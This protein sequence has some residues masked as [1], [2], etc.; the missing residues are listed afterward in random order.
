M[1]GFDGS[2]GFGSAFYAAYKH[3]YNPKRVAV[4]AFEKRP[5]FRELSKKDTFEGDTYNHS[6]FFEDP[7]GGSATFATAIAQQ[8]ASSQGARMVINRGREYQAI[9]MLNEE[10][11]ASRSDMGSLLRKKT[12]E[13]NRVIN[14]M[15]RRMDIALHGDG[16]GIIASFTT[17]ATLP[18]VSGGG[19]TFTLDTPGLGIRFSV[20]MYLQATQTYPAAGT[21]PTLLGGGAVC[22]VIAVN[23]NATS[24]TI[25][26]AGTP[27]STW[28]LATNQQYFVLRNGEG[29]GFG[30]N[31]INGGVSGLKAWL[32][33]TAPVPGGGDSF[34]GYD[35]SQD[36]QRLAGSRYSASLGEKYESTFQNCSAELEL[37]GSNPT[38]ILMNPVDLN[39]YSQE[40]GNKV[41]YSEDSNAVTGLKTTSMLVHGQSGDMKAL[42]DPQVDPGTFFMLD[43]ETW[44]INHLDGLP[45]LIDSDGN[46]SLRDTTGQT[47][48]IALQWRAWY[49]LVCDAPGKNLRGTFAA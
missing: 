1:P 32:P 49:N 15:S 34:W 46:G 33:A 13:T 44:W 42:S 47:D 20:G 6:I 17:P 45:H 48:S 3:V 4:L 29:V 21:P 41:R 27:N 12:H 16:T 36:P 43:M 24:S 11:R 8:A 30:L 14:E 40:L 10:I 19:T 39:K 26:L 23:R 18:T 31:L 5:F 7:Q 38:I 37:Q 22:Q 35:R 9:R 28:A 2:G 25:T